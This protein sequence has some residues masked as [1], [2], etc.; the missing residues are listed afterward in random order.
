MGDKTKIEWT[1]ASWNPIRGCTRVSE[2]CRH[3]YAERVAAR[4][5]GPG[6]AYEGLAIMK[7]GE[8]HWTGKMRLIDS[9]LGLPLR[10]K[11]PRR[12]F[13]NSMSDLFHGDVPNE[14]IDSVFLMMMCAQRHIFQIL[15]KRPQRMK[16]YCGS[17]ATR[18]R[19]VKFATDMACDIPGVTFKCWSENDGFDGIKL[20]NVWLGVSVENQQTAD[21][22]IPVLLE[23]PAAI[24]WVSYEPALGPVNFCRLNLG[25][26][27]TGYGM[28]RVERNALTPW[29]TIFH[30]PGE[31]KSADATQDN[32]NRGTKLDWLVCG[33][34]SGPGAR[35]MH[36]DWARSARDQCVAAKTGPPA[37]DGES[38]VG[39]H[40]P[41]FF[42]QWGEYIEIPQASNGAAQVDGESSLGEHPDTEFT[43]T[44]VGQE[45]HCCGGRPMLLDRV[46]KRAADRLLDGREWNEYPRMGPPTVRADFCRRSYGL[47]DRTC[48][49]PPGHGGKHGPL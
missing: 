27:K 46:G 37:V 48:M 15:T 4:F 33:G 9:A 20:P 19:I 29:E 38:S 18:D 32:I 43:F 22:R 45:H 1:D 35:P 49:K 28:R 47:N 31:P 10:W 13:V 16:V 40:V 17:N 2:G 36:P 30:K 24:R 44:V 26:Q 41:F 42:K 39:D 3:C 12:I 7:N 11:K 25:D 5:S 8:P 6:Q 14:W 23:T 34:E 21:E